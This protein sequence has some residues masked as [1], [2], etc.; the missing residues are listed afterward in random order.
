M[1]TA[2]TATATAAAAA[3]CSHLNRSATR[4]HAKG[5]FLKRGVITAFR[6]YLHTARVDTGDKGRAATG[7]TSN[8]YVPYMKSH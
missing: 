1:T 4:L 2:A 3:A 6:H 8:Y 5:T 7:C